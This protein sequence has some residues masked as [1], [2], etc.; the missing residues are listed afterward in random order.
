[1]LGNT[2]RIKPENNEGGQKICPPSQSKDIILSVRGLSAEWRS[3]FFS[4]KKKILDDI[5]VDIPQ[6]KLVAILGR[7][8]VGKTS[9]VNCIIGYEPATEGKVLI[10]KENFNRNSEKQNALIGYVPQVDALRGTLTVEEILNTSAGL[11]L[12]GKVPKDEIQ[13]RL[14]NVVEQLSLSQEDLKKKAAV[15][16]AGEKKKVSIAQEL[17]SNPRILFLDEPTSGMDP[18]AEKELMQTLSRMAHDRGMT[19]VVITHSLSHIDEYD[20]LLFF[21]PKGRLCFSGTP[22]EAKTYFH[23]DDIEEIYSLI[24]NNAEEYSRD[25]RSKNGGLLE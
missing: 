5:Y 19:L 23:V 25:C 4:K 18:L 11:K 14:S 15:L 9:F 1:M 2:N 7:I 3:H 6:G 10:N 13:S 8:G 16:S 17:L 21:G 20:L 22:T 24:D 12:V